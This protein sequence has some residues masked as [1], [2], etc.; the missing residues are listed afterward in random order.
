[1]TWTASGDDGSTGTA[2]GYIV[3]YSTVSLI[4]VLN[5]DSANTYS[6]SWEPLAAGSTEI[7]VVSGLWENTTYWFAVEVCDE[8]PN[9][10]GISNSPSATTASQDG[11]GGGGGSG[12]EARMIAVLAI[13]GVVVLVFLVA[14]VY[15]RQRRPTTAVLVAENRGI[16]SEEDN[17]TEEAPSIAPR[18]LS[19]SA[20][21]APS[22]GA[23]SCP[24]CGVRVKVLNA[25]FCWNCGTSV[26]PGVDGVLF[27]RRGKKAA[28]AGKCMVC[29]SDVIEG[30][31]AVWCPYCGGIAHEPH[32]REWLHVK[33][34]CP[35]CS[36]HLNETDLG[37]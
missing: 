2:I 6:Q 29:K 27:R 14:L 36:A 37:E 19:P 26:E 28:K 4:D 11:G 32:F 21:T 30:A 25:V 8:I 33:D 5:W 12:A 22:V 16:V 17:E 9:Y 3:K 20:R 1:L 35:V 23:D 10:S 31:K 15:V 24:F 7:H 34:Y 18:V 13:A